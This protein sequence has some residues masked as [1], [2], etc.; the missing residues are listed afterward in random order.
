M[1]SHRHSFLKR[2]F[3]LTY[4]LVAHL[5]GAAQDAALQRLLALP[6]DTAKVNRLCVHAQTLFQKDPPAAKKISQQIVELSRQLKYDVGLG[7]GLSYLAYF[8]NYLDADYPQVLRY[9]Q[10]ALIYYKR[11]N[12][13]IGI[14]KCYGNLALTYETLNQNDSGIIYRMKAI[15]LLEKKPSRQ[16]ATHYIN[17]GVQFN[18]RMY[19]PDKALF[20]YKKA[21]EV[22]LQV[23]DSARI[24]VARGGMS[25]IYNEKS[26]YKEALDYAGKAVAMGRIIDDYTGLNYA[27]ESYGKGMLELKRYPEAVAAAK[28]SVHY[29]ELASYTDGF[30]TGAVTWAQA[31]Q[32]LGDYKKAATV[33]EKA[34]V[35]AK[36][37]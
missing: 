29:A 30:L 14:S 36:N 25:R 27:L 18:N 28:E 24:V 2:T 21:E 17:M 16:L 15:A 3:I 6:N 1:K 32:K 34:I 33:L 35:K 26:M 22:A 19:N 20:Y 11:A 12:D 5:L 10:E 13:T 8:S 31:L 23:S 4:F 37:V 9:V 7:N